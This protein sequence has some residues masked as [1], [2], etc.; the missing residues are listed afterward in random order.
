[1]HDLSYLTTVRVLLKSVIGQVNAI[2]QQIPG[3]G[4]SSLERAHKTV[5]LSAFQD[6][7]PPGDQYNPDFFGRSVPNC[8]TRN[9][10][11]QLAPR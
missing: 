5:D 7:F 8:L 10:Y 4:Q 11:F 3:G 1:M 9:T 2:F 6:K